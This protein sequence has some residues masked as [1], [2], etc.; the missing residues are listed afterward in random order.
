MRIAQV[1]LLHDT[2][3]PWP[4][5]NAGRAASYLIEYTAGH[6]NLALNTPRRAASYTKS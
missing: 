2:V 6:F 5:S 1:S 4:S 3:A